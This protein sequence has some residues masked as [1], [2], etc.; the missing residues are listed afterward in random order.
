MSKKVKELNRITIIDTIG[1]AVNE[2]YWYL[3][4]IIEIYSMKEVHSKSTYYTKER[5][6]SFP[7]CSYNLT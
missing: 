4:N 2:I 6:P 3:H 7:V 5:I 1:V